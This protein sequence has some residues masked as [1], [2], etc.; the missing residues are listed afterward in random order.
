MKPLNKTDGAMWQMEWNDLRK[1]GDFRRRGI[2][3]LDRYYLYKRATRNMK[4]KMKEYL[5][6]HDKEY[7]ENVKK[8]IITPDE[9]TMMRRHK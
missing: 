2:D 6:K 4:L 3:A 9:S 5:K 7:E 1:Y 8:E